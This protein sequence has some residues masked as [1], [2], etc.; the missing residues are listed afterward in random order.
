MSINVIYSMDLQALYVQTITLG[1]PDMTALT[2]METKSVGSRWPVP[3]PPAGFIAR[4]G[5]YNGS[6]Y[7]K[8]NGTKYK[9]QYVFQMY[10]DDANGGYWKDIKTQA[11][12]VIF[13]AMPM[14]E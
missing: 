2:G 10:V 5:K 6:V 9:K 13:Q 3:D 1:D 7:M 11:L 4:P 12:S 14:A 8:C